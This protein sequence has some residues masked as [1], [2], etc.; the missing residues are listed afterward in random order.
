MSQKNNIRL[1]LS[2]VGTLLL[3]G[4]QNNNVEPPV[5][6]EQDGTTMELMPIST[7]FLDVQPWGSSRADYFPYPDGY[8]P[9]DVLYPAPV[10]EYR[11]IGVFMTPDRKT[12]AG[13]FIY[14]GDNKWKSTI[15]VKEGHTY[16]VYG[17][18]PREGAVDAEVNPLPG[19]T[20]YAPGAD[21]FIEKYTS[22]TPADVCVIVGVRYAFEEEEIA[23]HPLD[24]VPLGQFEYVGHEEGQNRIFVLLKH[25]YA[26]IHFKVQIDPE[27]HKLRNIKVKKV[28]LTAHEIPEFINLG[29]RLTANTEGKDPTLDPTN[30]SV[31]NI[32]YGEVLGDNGLPLT[33][34]DVTVTIYENADGYEVLETEPD[35]FLGCYVPGRY[36]F[37]LRTTYDVYDKNQK[38]DGEGNPVFDGEGNP[39]Y[40]LVREDCVAENFI[41]RSIIPDLEAGEVFTVNMLVKPTYL[42][43]M[44]EPDLD[45]PKLITTP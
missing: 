24:M 1:L 31:S 3:A 13:D 23:G 12:P 19:E 26:G 6:D 30:P 4:C 28:E 8:V 38:K 22:L 5:V 43:Q 45:N 9:Y 33:P 10:L 34:T 21:L 17:F 27:Y 37:T 35:G 15:L 32:E 44:S 7:R 40:N 2:F 14:E 25:L 11:K 16:Y 36:A 20:T 18:M 42:Y 29:V 39:V 41:N